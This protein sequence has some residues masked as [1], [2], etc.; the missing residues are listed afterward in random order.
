MTR[1]ELLDYFIG[2]GFLGSIVAL[3]LGTLS[4]LRP[5]RGAEAS[6]TGPI[7]VGE[8]FEIAVGEAKAV[9]VREKSALVIHTKNGFVALSSIC[10]HAECVVYWDEEEQLVKCP[11]HAGVF[12]SNG[13]RLAGPPPRGLRQYRVQ[14]VNEK[15]IVEDA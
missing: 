6:G 9:K 14:V 13:N 3:V 2:G 12:D 7:E 4:Y 5:G 8:A 11:C 1:R 10:P 15:I